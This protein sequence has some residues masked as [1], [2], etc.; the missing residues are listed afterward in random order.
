MKTDYLSVAAVVRGVGP[1]RHLRC[2]VK[3]SLYVLLLGLSICLGTV[4]G[5]SQSYPDSI[6]KDD[7]AKRSSDIHWPPGF[8]PDGAVLF[9][10]N[11][12][13]IKAPS[14]TV[15]RH[16]VEAQK[17]P[18]WYPNSEDVQ[19]ANDRSGALQQD[20]I[21]EWNTFGLPVT[22]IVHEFVPDSRLGWFGKSRGLDAVFYHTWYLVSTLDGC[23]MITEEVVQGPG[24]IAFRERDPSG[25]HRSHEIWLN[26]LKQLSENV[27]EP[28]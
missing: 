18:T 4:S 26:K 20:G 16:L 21:F 13:F 24:A 2:L 14:A 9:A 6:I 22:S 17:W 10:H 5:F 23:Q 7:L 3:N 27:A 15:W 12:I 19:I 25:L 8:S 1:L 11:S 28:Q